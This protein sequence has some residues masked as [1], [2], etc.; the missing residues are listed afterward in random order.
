MDSPSWETNTHSAYQE[1][2][3]LLRNSKG[4]YYV[5]KRLP[6]IIILSQ[7]NPVHIVTPYSFKI[8]LKYSPPIYAY[9]S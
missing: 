3:Y 7:I 2:P 8:H 5:Q 4:H 6:L 9:V 1:I